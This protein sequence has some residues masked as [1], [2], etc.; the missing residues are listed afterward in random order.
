MN[1]VD[2][3]ILIIVT[4]MTIR[5]FSKG[6]ILETTAL[7]GLLI[8]FFLASLYYKPL[9]VKLA[10]FL[11]NHEVLLALFCFFLLFILIFLLIRLLATAAR[12]ALRLAFL[13]WLDRI[14]GGLFGLIK[15]VV[16]VMVLVALLLFFSP[17][18]S[19]L[20]RE[21]LF[22]SPMQKFTAQLIRFIPSS[23]IE[24]FQTKRKKW[25]EYWWGKGQNLKNLH[26]IKDHE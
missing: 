7:F 4:L 6:I 3:A 22:Y 10:R 2:L 16:V 25:Q 12:G 19:S 15:G 1:I 20:M 9:S 17:K 8:S 13:G 14:L 18:A 5:G 24:D 21:S 11:P 26:K 23:I